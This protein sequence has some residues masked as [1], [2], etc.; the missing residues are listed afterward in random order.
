MEVQDFFVSSHSGRFFYECIFS[1][2]CSCDN[3]TK[4]VKVGISDNKCTW[5]N[6]TRGE[7]RFGGIEVEKNDFALNMQWCEQVSGGDDVVEFCV[8]RSN[9]R[10][11]VQH[12]DKLIVIGQDFM[13]QVLGPRE[14]RPSRPRRRANNDSLRENDRPALTN[15]QTTEDRWADSE[16][17]RVCKMDE[18]TRNMALNKC[19]W[20]LLRQQ[21]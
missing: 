6:K 10:P 1:Q 17:T 11:V 14:S 4:R 16:W 7:H 21:T 15:H 8:D 19:M 20:W 13:Q 12:C 3:G 9:P 2:K 5:L 18:T